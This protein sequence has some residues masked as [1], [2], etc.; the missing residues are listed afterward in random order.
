MGKR[1]RKR[2]LQRREHVPIPEPVPEPENE[3]TDEKYVA[4]LFTSLAVA[5]VF[6]CVGLLA[7]VWISRGACDALSLPIE[8]L[9]AKISLAKDTLALELSAASPLASLDFDEKGVALALQQ[10]CELRRDDELSEANYLDCT[11]LA[12]HATDEAHRLD[13][14]IASGET[15]LIVAA[16]RRAAAAISS[17]RDS[18][19][20]VLQLPASPAV[21]AGPF[22]LDDGEES[23][24]MAKPGVRPRPPRIPF[25]PRLIDPEQQIDQSPERQQDE[26]GKLRDGK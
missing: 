10:C 24:G 7:F 6:V 11:A 26:Q 22:R 8:R 2:Q 14:A 18:L 9:G 20:E 16:A 15:S 19:A 3:H 23:G 4:R 5:A 12:R 1:N 17:E 13:E 21:S 25:T